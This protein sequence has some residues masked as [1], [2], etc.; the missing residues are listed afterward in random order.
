M[1]INHRRVDRIVS[2][3]WLRF[4]LL[5]GM[6][7]LCAHLYFTSSNPSFRNLTIFPPCRPFFRECSSGATDA[8]RVSSCTI[9][10]IISGRFP[11]AV[12]EHAH[13][14]VSRF[15][16]RV[17]RG[18]FTNCDGFFTRPPHIALITPPIT[19]YDYFSKV[20]NSS[21][22]VNI[23]WTK[24]YIYV[25]GS[26][27]KSRMNVACLGDL[28]AGKI[29]KK[30]RK[31]ARGHQKWTCMHRRKVFDTCISSGYV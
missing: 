7:S 8:G 11:N 24:I 20:S 16:L 5:L 23:T 30:N 14:K 27:W 1:H 26:V 22:L 17:I 6:G 12:Y 10:R 25:N 4:L 9:A 29:L 2:R 31:K 3:I 19:L 18:G 13:G 15:R 28:R 21:Y